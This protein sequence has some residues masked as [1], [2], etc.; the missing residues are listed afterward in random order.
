MVLRDPLSRFRDLAKI[1]ELGGLVL[2]PSERSEL[3][4]DARDRAYPEPAVDKELPDVFKTERHGLAR[5]FLQ[6]PLDL[7]QAKLEVRLNVARRVIDLVGDTGGDLAQEG[8]PI[9]ALKGHR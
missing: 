7:L 1:D 8:E 9:R 2:L 5:L 6:R 3:G 4:Y